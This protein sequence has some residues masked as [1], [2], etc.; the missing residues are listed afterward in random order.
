MVVVLISY[1]AVLYPSIQRLQL[2]VRFN[3]T[4][5]LSRSETWVT[6][7]GCVLAAKNTFIIIMYVFHTVPDWWVQ[8]CQKHPRPGI[9]QK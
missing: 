3:L 7:L 4:V 8:P 1:F 5:M 2:M 9:H 6:D